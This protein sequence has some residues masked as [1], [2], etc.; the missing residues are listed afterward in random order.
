M[1]NIAKH[2]QAHLVRLSLR[3][4]EN[5]IEWTIEDNGM[6]FDLEK[7]LSSEGSKRGLGLGSMRERAELSGGTFTIESTL[8]K[9]TTIKAVW[10]L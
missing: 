4:Q 5:R 9:G 6:G 8:G 10:P 3:K 7:I 1:N 2:S